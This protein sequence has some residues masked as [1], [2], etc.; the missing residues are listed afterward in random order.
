MGCS[1]DKS[2]IIKPNDQNNPKT[3]VMTTTT[4]SNDQKINNNIKDEIEEM[5]ITD[6]EKNPMTSNIGDFNVI[7]KDENEE[8]NSKTKVKK[9]NNENEEFI[10][11]EIN[12]NNIIKDKLYNVEKERKIKKNDEPKLF[13]EKAIIKEKI[14]EKKNKKKT[15]IKDEINEED[16]LLD[17]KIEDNLNNQQNHS[18]KEKVNTK[19]KQ[20]KTKENNAIKLKKNKTKENNNNKYSKNTNNSTK[21]KDEDSILEEIKE[22]NLINDILDDNFKVKKSIE[23]EEK[24]LNKKDINGNKS[25]EKNKA[26]N[27]III[28]KEKEKDNISKNSEDDDSI[29]EEIE[30]EVDNN[31][32]HEN[33]FKKVENQNENIEYSNNEEDDSIKEEIEAY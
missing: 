2:T 7:K 4:T 11:E 17:G 25:L 8:S 28:K 26:K 31:I 9:D 20:N 19:L 12:E 30:G 23:K 33:S 5:Q 16:L 1:N 6:K 22:K 21:E 14:E 3:N 18:T 32:K 10:I 24:N 15:V 29:K 13:E 27:N